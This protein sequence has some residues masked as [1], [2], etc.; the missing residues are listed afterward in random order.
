MANNKTGLKKAT[1]RGF[2]WIL[3]VLGLILVSFVLFALNSSVI[4]LVVTA[5]SVEH[6][7]STT[8]R[9][10]ADQISFVLSDHLITISDEAREIERAPIENQPKELDEIDLSVREFLHPVN[11]YFTD[12]RLYFV[13]HSYPLPE[14]YQRQILEEISKTEKRWVKVV[15]SAGGVFLILHHDGD[16]TRFNGTYTEYSIY[17]S[18]LPKIVDHIIDNSVFKRY[19]AE[20]EGAMFEPSQLFSRYV[21]LTITDG[22]NL[23]YERGPREEAGGQE[24]TNQP[25]PYLDSLRLTICGKFIFESVI[26][27]KLKNFNILFILG[28]AMIVLGVI[29]L[30]RKRGN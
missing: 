3:F 6:P 24:Y 7:N 5:D 4:A 2:L 9:L 29:F 15:D 28:L 10:L 19:F 21:Y 18:N 16:T 8:A 13:Q 20:K 26:V 11:G 17:R 14:N 1:G 25:L 22:D 12:A 27:Q 23:L 30:V